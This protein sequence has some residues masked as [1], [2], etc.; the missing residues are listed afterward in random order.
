MVALLLS[1]TLCCWLR[2]TGPQGTK[3]GAHAPWLVPSNRNTGP[4][5][6]VFLESQLEAWVQVHAHL[7][8]PPADFYAP[9]TR[10]HYASLSLGRVVPSLL[11]SSEREHHLFFQGKRIFSCFTDPNLKVTPKRQ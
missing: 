1:V 11:P 3:E 5:W 9:N 7:T 2:L 8:W 10:N 6:R 4:R